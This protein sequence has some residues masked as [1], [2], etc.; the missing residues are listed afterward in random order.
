MNACLRRQCGEMKCYR[1]CCTWTIL[2]PWLEPWC[3]FLQDDNELWPSYNRPTS[4]PLIQYQMFPFSITQL[5]SVGCRGTANPSWWDPMKECCRCL[6]GLLN[7]RIL[8]ATV[9]L[10][11]LFKENLP[12]STFIPATGF[13]WWVH[14]SL[15]RE[16]ARRSPSTVDLWETQLVRPPPVN[17][18]SLTA[19]SERTVQMSWGNRNTFG[20]LFVCL[21]YCF[22]LFNK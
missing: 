3:H 12:L 4:L 16:L 1:E 20:G 9:D 21:C 13:C 8:R 17:Q 14:I 22:I 10:K 11:Q 6:P 7:Q 15:G 5:H 18:D 19:L 2:S